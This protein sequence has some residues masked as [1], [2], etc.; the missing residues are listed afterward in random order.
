MIDIQLFRNGAESLNAL[1]K[2][3]EKRFAS[4]KIIDEI[5]N[6]DNHCR[7]K[8]FELD[9]ERKESAQIA[10]KIANLRKSGE[11]AENL[12]KELKE[13]KLKIKDAEKE[14][15]SDLEKRNEL[16]N[17]VGNIVHD[18]VPVSNDEVGKT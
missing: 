18:E 1:K 5:Y 10:K 11:N 9:Q 14:L 3:Q 2:S 12:E 17:K 13:A 16:L 7:A 6:L 15:K 8:T 4:T